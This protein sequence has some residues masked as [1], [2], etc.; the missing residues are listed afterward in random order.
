[1]KN[2]SST[3]GN[4]DI[5]LIATELFLFSLPC[6]HEHGYAFI[7]QNGIISIANNYQLEETVIQSWRK[8]VAST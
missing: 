4:E 8:F 7:I 2:A 6:C 1:M 3:S 5:A